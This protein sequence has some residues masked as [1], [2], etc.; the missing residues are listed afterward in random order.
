MDTQARNFDFGAKRI[1]E[2]LV[3]F[4]LDAMRCALR[5]S[6]VE[7]IVRVVEITALPH[8]PEI[9]LGIINMHG[10]IIPV[11]DLRKRFSL[12]ERELDL[13]SRLMI[14]RTSRRRLALAADAVLGV[15]QCTT[16]NTTAGDSIL[17]GLE[18]VQGVVRLED[19]LALIHNLETFLSLEE[20]QILEQA[21]KLN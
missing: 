11:I 16:E 8:A 20:E 19:G 5:L 18:Y 15:V 17:P 4:T 9:V 21:M 14:A 7:R 10:E 2:Q 3:V 13:G 1:T 12:P 6:C